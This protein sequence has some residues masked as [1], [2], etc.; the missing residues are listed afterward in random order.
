MLKL[1]VVVLAGV[2]VAWASVGK[3]PPQFKVPQSPAVDYVNPLIGNGGIAPSVTGGMI[4]S[5]APPF[6]MTRWI[7]QTRRNYVSRTPYN[8][9]ADRISGFQGT[10]QPA[11][12]MGESGPVGVVPGFV[13]NGDASKV[14]TDFDQRGLKKVAGSEVITPSYYRIELE[15]DVDGG[16]M[17]VVEQSATSRVGHLRF[18]FHPSSP[19]FM[20]SLV[21]EAVR[22]SITSSNPNNITF[23]MGQVTLSNATS[24]STPFEICGWNDE[25]QDHII[26]PLSIAANAAKFK[27][28][29]C[30]HLSG[31][32]IMSHGI[33]QNETVVADAVDMSGQILSSYVL[34]QP[35]SSPKRAP[36]SIVVDL[37]VG[38]SFI[39]TDMA[40]GH[41]AS[42]A[43]PSQ[44]LED[45]A[46][47]VRT[48]WA[49][50]LDRIVIEGAS[51]EMKE[52]FYTAAFHA[53]Q[54]PSEQHENGMYFSG[55]D[56]QVH[57]AA[58]SYTGYSIWDTYRAAWAWEIL[59]APERIP[60]M[61][62]SMLADFKEAGR[63]PMWKNIV[64]TN[65]MVGTHA[66]SLI[67]EAAVKGVSGFDPEVAWQAVLKDATVPPVKDDSVLY[68]D[69]QENVD[70][71]ARAGLSTVYADK[72]WVAADVHSESGSRTL[73]Y[74]YDDFS[75]AMLGRAIGKP[76]DVVQ[77][78]LDR[79][80]TAPFTLW[81]EATGFMEARN[82]DGAFAG[83]SAGW[84]EGDK[85]TYTFDVVHAVP[86][87][88]EKRGGNASF[89]KSLDAHFD[90]GHN[91]HRNE[92]SHHIPYLYALGGAAFKTQEKVREIANVNYNN[93]PNGLSGNEDC[94]QT[95]AWFLFT[96]MGFYP[97]NP[98]SGEYVV[99]SPFF[100]KITITLPPSP[101]SS[102]EAVK[103]NRTLTIIAKGA[104]TKQYVKSLMINGQPIDTPVISHEQL[105]G[106]GEVVFEMSDTVE[107]W[108]NPVNAGN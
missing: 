35:A 104:A 50:K 7:A 83:E 73:D 8:W 79:A 6:G 80:M 51:E 10:R 11:I 53:L 87:L 40:R 32:Q 1:F 97:V 29:F 17:V 108:G 56:G 4:P 96:A 43:P 105:I 98:A 78:L 93:T 77:P 63:L 82:A 52:T 31:A 64:E 34:L 21:I 88:V 48:A 90:G 67:A 91:D 59:M 42:E 95:S 99:G 45:T 66:D 28:F 54:Y 5:T 33:V 36:P 89:V 84:T 49:E 44:S 26:T 101:S 68:S 92:P 38:T 65:I 76:E 39:S 75:A 12:W 23:P 103:G 106:G 13:A 14:K 20:P 46:R 60:G 27:G 2:L 19:S 61:V 71:E 58:E 86:Q 24:H 57:E 85:W 3:V 70:F 72:G 15:D 74:A 47:I 9:T 30:A 81:N 55:N 94:G 69:R 18:T 102:L 41:I 22:P 100:D 16:G 107:E 37:R 25:R 62:N